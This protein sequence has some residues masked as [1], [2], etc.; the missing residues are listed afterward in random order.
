MLFFII[1]LII[2]ASIIIF[3]NDTKFGRGILFLIGTALLTLIG[4]LAFKPLWNLSRLTFLLL[5]F[6][7][8]LGL[9]F[10]IF[11]KD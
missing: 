5:I 10:N 9:F 2:I 8:I 3:A 1:I 4:G 7:L 11:R 6:M